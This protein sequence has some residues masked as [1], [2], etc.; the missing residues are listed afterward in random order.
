MFARAT[1]LHILR[2]SLENY[3]QGQEGIERWRHAGLACGI[4]RKEVESM[5]A[6]Y[7][8]VIHPDRVQ[9]EPE[10]RAEVLAEYGLSKAPFDFTLPQRVLASFCEYSETPY[11]DL[12]P[13]FAAERD[14]AELYTFRDTHYTVA[15]NELAGRVLYQ[16]LTETGLLQR[17][18]LALPTG[19][20]DERAN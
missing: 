9:V 20:A 15:G 12:L 11:V 17:R 8:M 7:V 6:E 10:I 13:A 19:V 1:F 5:G 18:L 2:S 4:I 3:R 16:A 14:A